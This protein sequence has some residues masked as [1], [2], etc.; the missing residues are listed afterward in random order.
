MPDT[1]EPVIN[2]KEMIEF[3]YQELVKNGYA[4][5][6]DMIELVLNLEMDYMVKEGFAE[7]IDEE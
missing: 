6:E 5:N 3:I 4:A 7:V 2:D 1:S